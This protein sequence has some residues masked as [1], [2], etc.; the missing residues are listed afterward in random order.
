[1]HKITVLY[2]LPKDPEHFKNYYEST[3]LP[4]SKKLPGLLASRYSFSVEGLGAPSP[5]FAIWEGEF[6]S[7][8]AAG[9]AMQSSVGQEVVADAENYA[10]GGLTVIHFTVQ[11]LEG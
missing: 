5:F 10:D 9:A 3:H 8:E 11:E 6:S 2:G 7:A 4:I 1:M